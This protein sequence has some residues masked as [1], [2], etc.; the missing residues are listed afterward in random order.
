MSS[1]PYSI[2]PVLFVVLLITALLGSVVAAV[3]SGLGAGPFVGFFLCAFIPVPVAG[4]VRYAVATAL[5][6]A[7]GVETLVPTAGSYGFR[8]TVGAATAA[9]L[10]LALS[11]GGDRFPFNMVTGALAAVL[12]S[13]V[14]AVVF[15]L[16]LS[17]R[18]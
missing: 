13:L 12:C 10:A 2:T 18:K 16:V 4:Q 9:V 6:A 7:N 8:T 1:A 5:A 11:Q 15:T 3:A 17:S 14:L